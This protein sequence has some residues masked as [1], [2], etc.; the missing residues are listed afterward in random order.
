MQHHD[1]SKYLSGLTVPVIFM[2]GQY[3]EGTP[4]AAFHYASL[5]PKGI[6]EVAVI[7]SSGHSACFERPEE[8]NTILSQFCFRIDNNEK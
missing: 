6:A 3:D 7:P 2:P 1:S 4:E 5:C 8:F